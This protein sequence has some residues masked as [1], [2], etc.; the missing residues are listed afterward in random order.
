MV[1]R[2]ST[3]VS[4]SASW[5]SSRTVMSPS[6]SCRKEYRT[7]LTLL[8]TSTPRTTLSYLSKRHTS[9][10]LRGSSIWLRRYLCLFWPSPISRK[11]TSSRAP[12]CLHR[13]KSGNSW[14]SWI[15]HHLRSLSRKSSKPYKFYTTPWFSQA[16]PW[17]THKLWRDSILITAFPSTGHTLSQ[18]L[19][20]ICTSWWY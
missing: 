7:Y 9:T 5:R 11:W 15:W 17:A 14:K 2:K 10:T 4:W 16:W 20:F 19:C 13:S 8:T 6:L 1:L 3:L 12:N 18:V